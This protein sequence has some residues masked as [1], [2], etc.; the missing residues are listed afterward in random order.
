MM[1][2]SRRL[3]LL[4]QGES[5]WSAQD[6][7]AARVDV[8]VSERGRAQACRC[9]ELMARAG[10]LPDVVHTSLLRRAITTAGRALDAADRH[11]IDVHRSWRPNERHY[12]TLH[13]R[14]RRQVRDEFGDGQLQRW[15]RSYEVAPPRAEQD[16]PLSQDADIRYRKLGVP[17]PPAESLKDVVARLLPYAESS[18]VPDLRA[19][20]TVLVVAHGNA[21]RALVE[22][23]YGI[24]GDALAGLNIP[25]VVPLRYDLSDTLRPLVP[26]G[27][28]LSSHENPGGDLRCRQ[29]RSRHVHPSC[30]FTVADT[31]AGA[32][33]A[34]PLRY[35]RPVT[36]CTRPR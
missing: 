2:A 1:R 18:I 34:W 29:R 8:L 14:N 23:I 10:L 26:G 15:R 31:A 11:W 12:G 33:S 16:N 24:T 28:Y 21:L 30:S 6:L 22:L 4:R 9:G 35:V 7:F 32:G 13:G 25:T 3:V 5:V 27:A 19:G 36:R 17:V 20:R